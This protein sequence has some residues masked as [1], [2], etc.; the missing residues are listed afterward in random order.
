M[1]FQSWL[2]NLRSAL[3]PRRG[4]CRHE[5][6][7]P[8]QAKVQSPKLEVLEDRSL[9]SFSPAV[10]YPVGGRPI[11]PWVQD[12]PMVTADF[13]NDTVL[14]LAV[15]NYGGNSRVSV[16][17]G[18]GDG[19]FQPAVNAGTGTVPLSLAVGDFDGDGNSDLATANAYDVSVLL[20]RGDGTFRTLQSFRFSDG[21]YPQAVAV[22]DFNGDGLLDLGVTSNTYYDYYG[23]PCYAT[24]LLGHGD[25]SFSG[26]N[27]TPLDEGY[28][29]AA[30]AADLNGDSIDDLV[31]VNAN[32]NQVNVLFGDSSGL[33]RAPSSF[34]TGNYPRSVAAGDLDG[35]GD[36]DLVTGNFY[37]D[38][39]SVLLGNGA[40]GFSAA[41]S[42]PSGWYPAAVVLGDFTGDGNI[43]VATVNYY[44]DNLSVL[45]GRGDGTFSP[46]I[47]FA[48]GSHPNG[49]AAG[50]FNGDGWLDVATSNN[51]GADVSVLINDQSWSSSPPPSIRVSDMTVTEPETGTWTVGFNVTLSYASDVDVTVH[52]ATADITAT[53]GSDYVA[54][55]GD[56]IIPA[57]QT[58]RAFAVLINGDR[59]AEPTETFAINLSAPKNATIGDAQAI[60]TIVNTAPRVTINEVTVTE[61]NAG[62]V[63]ATFT[64]SLSFAYDK[65]VT[66]HYATADGS[67]T[68]GSDYTAVSGEVT[69]APG[70][71]TKTITVAVTG[72]RTFEPDETFSVYLSASGAS[73][74]G[75][76]VA[77]IKDDE[78]RIRISDVA[79]KEGHAN[80][81]VFTF[82]V[83]LAAA[84][85]QPVTVNYATAD[86]TA[87][88]GDNDYVATSGTL[89]FAPGETTKTITVVVKGDKKKESNETFFVNLS[90]PSSNA[91]ISDAQGIGTILDDDR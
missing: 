50:D 35:D 42:Y 78:P 32:R 8:L 66:V 54:A 68:A 4:R 85:D 31:T 25:G 73:V 80:T 63:N 91:L 11:A 83:T 74:Y 41:V 24:V 60:C 82:T 49:V 89:T 88:V 9:L 40:G 72:D 52:Y 14:D 76:G 62:S 55:S 51:D 53:A 30:V 1:S 37:S 2:Q 65:A 20:G 46:W 79:R 39:V 86:G 58:I 47:N 34:T 43:D 21:E 5:R 77:T 19:S 70:E 81:T 26:P 15:A 23:G 45:P 12:Q 56:L 22:G 29:F 17:L 71:T 57:G 28:H 84:Y 59:F 44:D 18:N 6:R 16:L 64:V 87:T 3:A 69:F 33:L 10:S 38:K 48:V 13:N 7:G 36:T 27:I 67:A 90:D 61:G 75:Q